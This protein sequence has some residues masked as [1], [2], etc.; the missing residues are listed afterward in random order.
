MHSTRDRGYDMTGGSNQRVDLKL[1][2]AYLCPLLDAI[3]TTNMLMMKRQ[4]ST[5]TYFA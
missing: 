4:H 3:Y 2:N 1:H 5:W